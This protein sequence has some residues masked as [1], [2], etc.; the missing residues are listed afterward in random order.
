MRW[1]GH[2]WSSVRV[3]GEA[4]NTDPTMA[5]VA[6][7]GSGAFAVGY[8]E[9]D[10]AG[11]RQVAM[12]ITTEVARPMPAAGGVK[13]AQNQLVSVAANNKG[14]VAVGYSTKSPTKDLELI[15]TLRE[16]AFVRQNAPT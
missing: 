3:K 4:A 14:A 5:S 9:T 2:T 13:G 8:D 16:N 10:S 7:V 12:R 11:Y 15:D 6:A 1:N